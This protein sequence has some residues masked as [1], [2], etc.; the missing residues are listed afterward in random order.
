MKNILKIFKK[1]IVKVCTNWVALVVVIGLIILP[2]LYA[3]FNIKSSWDPYGNTKG[4]KIAI[5]NEDKGA[6]YNNKEINVGNELVDEL[7]KNDS[8][9]WQFVNANEAKVKV[10]RGEVF[11]S[12]VIPDNFSKDA[13]SL[14][15]KNIQ[16]PELIYTVNEGANA[17]APKITDKGV[18]TLKQNVDSNL[19]KTVNGIIFKIFNQIGIEYENERP[20]IKEGV[21]VLYDLNNNSDKIGNLINEAYNGTITINEMVDKINAIVPSFEKTINSADSILNSGEQFLNSSK[22][23]INKVAPMIKDDLALSKK[24]IDSTLSIMDSIND[25]LDKE[26]TIESLTKIKDKL[27]AAQG[28]NNSIIKMLSAINKDGNLDNVIGKFNN[29]NEKINIAVSA[30]N[31]NIDILNGNGKISAEDIQALKTKLQNISGALGEILNNYDSQIMPGINKSIDSLITFA[32]NGEETLQKTKDALPKIKEGLGV[33]KKGATISNEKLKTLK[34]NY[35]EIQKTL[36]N[37]VGKIKQIDNGDNVDKILDLLTNDWQGESDF[38]GNPVTIHENRLYQVPNYGSAMSPFYTTL[39]LWV[40]GLILVSI[41]T[42]STRGID[43]EK[44]NIK[45]YQ[46]FFGKYLTFL[47][48]GILQGFV[49]TMGDIFI[50]KTYVLNKVGFVLLGMFISIIFISIIYSTVSALGNIGKAVCIIFLVLQVAASG[51]TFPVEVMSGFF[52]AINPM[53]PFKYA[54]DGMR[55][56]VAGGV[57]DLFITDIRNLIFVGIG[58]LIVG[59]LVKKPLNKASAGFIKK[60]DESEIVG[61]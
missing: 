29:V 1:D 33:F 49:V 31:K 22:D 28:I 2:S 50:L 52:K 30:I 32:N 21:N 42:V 18:E 17:I 19:V 36:A 51:G 7:K 40:G 59:V 25:N 9:G 14:T 39:A 3:W 53:L 8:L 44:E 24:L 35:P 11:A 5:V 34:D 57:N 37:L 15:T 4:I 46:V 27:Q 58:F 54:I 10:E 56:L 55:Y 38:L 20:K 6:E 45:P 61:H 43:M 41:L 60:L 23:A 16:K 12:I 13:I 48:I 26:A 47:S